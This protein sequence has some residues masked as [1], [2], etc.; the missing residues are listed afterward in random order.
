[1][2]PA[3]GFGHINP[4]FGG[5]RRLGPGAAFASPRFSWRP[6]RGCKTNWA[7][8]GGTL[9][10]SS[11]CSGTRPSRGCT[12]LQRCKTLFCPF[13]LRGKKT[14]VSFSAPP[15]HPAAQLLGLPLPSWDVRS[16]R[17]GGSRWPLSHQTTNVTSVSQFVVTDGYRDG[18]ASA[19]G[20]GFSS[21][22]AAPSVETCRDGHG[23][24]CSVGPPR[25]ERGA[26][27]SD[28]LRP[29]G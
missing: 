11:H 18:D 3:D 24:R 2:P 21:A 16:R 27:G 4:I 7:E 10:C 13:F 5:Q 15:E 8:L 23:V 6:A 20:A 28:A 14:T 29:F 17:P 1:M 26:G 19:T 25:E 9:P 12:P 22:T